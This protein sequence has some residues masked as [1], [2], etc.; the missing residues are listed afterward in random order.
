METKYN[1]WYKCACK[2]TFCCHYRD[3]VMWYCFE[4][5]ICSQQGNH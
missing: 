4:L 3:C 1:I 5:K 2:C